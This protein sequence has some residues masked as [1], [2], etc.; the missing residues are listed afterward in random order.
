MKK[1]FLLTSIIVLAFSSNVFAQP[2]TLGWSTITPTS[3]ILSWNATPCTPGTVSLRYRVVGNVW[4]V[5]IVVTS[6]YTLTGLTANTAYEWQVKCTSCSGAACWSAAQSFSTSI[7]EISN[8][9]ISQPILCFGDTGQMQVDINQTSPVT[10]YK[11]VVGRYFGTFFLS[12]ST[13]ANTTA[14]QL[15]LNG[16]QPN[17]NYYVRLVDSTLHYTANGNSFSGTSTVGIYDEFGPLNFSQ[18]SAITSITSQTNLICNGGSNGTATANPSGGTPFAG[19]NPYTYSWNTIPV[20]TSQTATGLSAGTYTCTITDANG[21]QTIPSVTITQP[22]AITSITSQTNLIC[23]G[24]SNGTATADPSGGTPFAGPNPYT[25]SWNTTPIQTTQTATGLST[26]TYTCTITDANGCQTIPSVTIT[27]P[28]AA[29][30]APIP[31]TTNLSCNGGSNG[32]AT[33]NPSGGTPFAGP[34]PYTYSWNTIPVQTSQTATG[35]S[36]GTYTCTISDA[37]SCTFTTLPVTITGPSAITAT[38]SKTNITCNGFNNGTATA[39]ASGGTPFA[40]PNPYAYSWS[41]IPVQTSQTATGL[42][43]GTYTCTISDLNNCAITTSSVTIL[44]P[45][46][47]TATTSQTNITCNGFN[48]GT[49]TVNP[50]GGTVAGG[51]TYLWDDASAQT[52]Q[53]ATGLS[54]GS[55]TCSITDDNNCPAF[56]TPSV[57]ITQPLALTAATSQTYMTCN[58]GNNGTATAIASGGTPFTFDSQILSWTLVC[59]NFTVQY[60]VL[61]ASSWLNITGTTTSSSPYILTGLTANTSYEW[62]VKCTGQPWTGIPINTFITGDSYTYSWLPGGQTSSTATGLSAGTYTCTISDANSCILVANSVTIIDP[63]TLTADS[64]AHTNITCNGLTDGAATVVNPSGGTPFS[65]PNPYIY[66]WS[67]GQTTQTVTGLSPGTYTCTISDAGASCPFIV[68]AVITE[69]DLLEIDST[70]FSHISCFGFDDGEILS[71]DVLGGTSPFEYSVNGS[72]HYS[73][74]AYFNGYGPGTYTVEVFDANNCVG[75]DIIIISEPNELVVDITTSGWVFNSN[76]GLYS[77][78]IKCH[79]DNSGFANLTITGG[80]APYIRKLYDASSGILIT[81]TNLNSF[82]GLTAGEY[83]FKVIDAKGCTYSETIMFNQPSLI[84]HN[85]IPTHVTC[86]GWSNGSL[87][88]VISGGVGNATTYSYS[89]N[90]GANTYTINGIPVGTYTMTVTDENG[91]HSDSSFSINANNALVANVSSFI[92]ISC[93]DYCDGEIFTAVSGGMPN[94]N[95]TGNPIYNY[96]WDDV[97]SQTA[98]SAIGLCADNIS[99]TVQYSCIITDGQGCSVVLTQNL[100]QPDSLTVTAT[101]TSNYNL[102]DI[103]CYGANDGKLKAVAVGGNTPYDYIWSTGFTQNNTSISNITNLSAGTYTVVVEDSKGCLDT[104]AITLTEP[105]ELT[106]LVSQT[107]VNCFGIY[108][109]TITANADGGNPVNGIPPMYNYSFSS[110]FNQQVDVSTDVDVAPGIYTVTATDENGCT[111]TSGSIFISQP[112]DLLTIDLDSIDE[113]CNGNNGVVTS[114]VFG[115]TTPYTY[116]WSN[117]G[118]SASINSLSPGFYSVEVV[119][120]NGCVVNDTIRVNGSDEVFLPGNISSFDTTI[121]LGTTFELNVEE[122]LGFTYVWTN[123]NDTLL[124]SLINN[125]TNESADISV[126]P[127]D[128]I[129]IYT[130][131]IND[132]TCTS[133]YEVVATINVDFIDPMPASNPGVEYGNFPVVLN[134]ESIQIFSDNN[135]CE[136]YTWTWS[137][138]TVSQKSINVSPQESGWYYIDVKDYD[139]C[140]G[141]DSIYVVVGVKPYEAI[142]PNNDGFND[143]WTPLDIASYENALVQVFNRW[144]GLVF[145]SKGGQ[146]YQAWDGTNDGEELTVGTY[147]YIIDLN[148]GDEPQT[149]PITIIR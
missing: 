66:L 28:L 75:A 6:P 73:N 68:T 91:C 53:T 74:M 121:C 100:S 59:S 119:D 128:Y 124:N 39:I 115:G 16:F 131:N 20:Q 54:A 13:T 29:L 47:I 85:F 137:Q 63:S 17:Q 127:A 82:T 8:A 96:Q 31:T 93:Y 117:S 83:E 7:P 76:S 67:N 148:T 84:Q 111:V 22:S 102:E 14:T 58:G 116:A 97:L 23:N 25:Y 99:N 33:A 77:Y 70:E 101:I 15:N 118:I 81:T 135:N 43:A 94:F 9:F 146:N 46:A 126:T 136:D 87:T 90:T 105:T 34:N 123:G 86:S 109:G 144:G 92:N 145:E 108:D 134:G 69:P 3:A 57:T 26:L 30:T 139:G 65:G 114:F 41:T 51:Y 133:S 104:T 103:S 48:N 129:N 132:P 130:L 45:S 4:P 149:G 44:N 11:C 72:T 61:G 62:R 107:N 110:G 89:W 27:Q 147:Y 36:A 5:G 141:Y 49:A 95:N 106:I 71:I 138:D 56:I 42:S 32:A 2:T 143:T 140:L 24:G 78:Q 50:S 64:T 21:C 88:D 37:N 60:R 38:T 79:G 122:K 113:S 125:L 35:L 80:T 98:P 18:P 40:G 1:I 52:T 12:Y 112:T 10:T 142:T 120:G 55:Y 19:P